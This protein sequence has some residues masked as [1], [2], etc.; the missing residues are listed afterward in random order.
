MALLGV[1]A[2]L[3]A[4]GMELQIPTSLD[5]HSRGMLGGVLPVLVAASVIVGAF[6]LWAVY[7]RKPAGRRERGRILDKPAK[8]ADDSE[9][10]SSSH[11]RRRRRSR[12]R[13]H[14]RNP[15]LADTGGLPP[16]GAGDT[17]NPPL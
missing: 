6:V 7:L 12:S 16:L 5:S 9:G 14:Q 11:R 15:S 8:E 2:I 1:S 4:G 13:N 10:G 3:A 17:K